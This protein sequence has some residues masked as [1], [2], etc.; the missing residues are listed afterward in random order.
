[1]K[2]AVSIVEVGPRDGLQNEDTILDTDAKIE[3]IHRLVHAGASRIEAVS[4]VHPEAVPAMAD[5]ED[6]MSGIRR[7]DDVSI[8]GLVVNR[9]GF[10]RALDVDV[11]EINYVTVATETFSQ[12][13]QRASI[14]ETL[15]TWTELAD[16]AHD[17]GVFRTVTIGAS[18]G[19]PFEG[20]V[21]VEQ[22]VRIARRVADIGVEEI[23]LADTIGVGDPASVKRK[24]EAVGEATDGVALRCHFHNTRNTGIANAYAALEV[25]V[26]A[27][28]A[29]IGGIGGCPFAPAATGNIATEDLAY[30]LDR[31]AVPSGLDLPALLVDA[32]WIGE[33]LGKDEVPGLV[34]RAGLFP[35]QL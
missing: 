12:R 2:D 31:M 20:E 16:P 14:E 27:L 9:R 24:L 7:P 15:E 6:V 13:N 5:A 18:F 17:R 28:D 35:E 4:F 26:G 22:V 8:A 29:S 11:D 3:M 32:T 21:S 33:Q 23:C 30:M 19:C 34:S 1:M 10:E 25:G